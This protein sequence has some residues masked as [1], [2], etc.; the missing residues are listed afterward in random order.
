MNSLTARQRGFLSRPSLRPDRS[1]RQARRDIHTK[2]H[3]RSPL[4]PG[5]LPIFSA[6]LRSLT[7]KSGTRGGR[8]VGLPL[9]VTVGWPT[10]TILRP[11]S[12]TLSQRS[13]MAFIQCQIVQFGFC[14][15]VDRAGHVHPGRCRSGSV[16]FLEAGRPGLRR[17]SVRVP[18]AQDDGSLH[19]NRPRTM[20]A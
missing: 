6:E 10:N 19:K 16:M 2:S 1:G 18:N 12:V 15:H 5:G 9:T 3:R 4:D 11:A 13:K 8:N 14:L 7:P 17:E 20:G